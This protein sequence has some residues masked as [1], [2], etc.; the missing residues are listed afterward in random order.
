[1]DDRQGET[2]LLLQ[3]ARVATQCD[4]GNLDR[5]RRLVALEISREKHSTG[6]A[7]TDRSTKPIPLIDDLADAETRRGTRS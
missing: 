5:D 7:L 6:R 1:M 2:R 4:F 3:S